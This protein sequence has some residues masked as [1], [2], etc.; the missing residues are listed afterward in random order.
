MDLLTAINDIEFCALDLETTG[1]N[2]AFDRIVEIG[3]VRF[4]TAGV[5]KEYQKLVNPGISIPENVIRIHGI[6]DGMVSD[7][8]LIN[9]IL[10]EFHEFFKG[11]ILVIQ[12]PR[13]DLSFIERA[14]HVRDGRSPELKAIDTV[15]LAQK[16]FPALPNHK[17]STLTSHL[18]L[19]LQSHRALDDAIA[20]MSIFNAVIKGRGIQTYGELMH[21]HG[22]MGRPGLRYPQPSTREPWRRIVIGKD[23]RIR[24]KDTDGKVTSRLI[25]PREFIQYGKSS[26]ILAYCYLR[27]S[28]R[29]FMA[30][31]IVSIE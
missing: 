3:A 31:R 1:V 28:E 27:E 12:N 6:T 15:N 17:I 13:F 10:D 19:N 4:T 21:M 7:A 5:I 20:C 14:F 23:I 25:H 18:G 16:H 26:Y 29:C 24:Y 2:P 11:A 22:E 30:S 9:D 8:P